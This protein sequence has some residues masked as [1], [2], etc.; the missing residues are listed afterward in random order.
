MDLKRIP[1]ILRHKIIH[2]ELEP[3]LIINVSDLAENYGVSRTPIK[4]ALILLQGE[5]WVIRHGSRFMVTPLSIKRLTDNIEIRMLMEPQAYIWAMQRMTNAELNELMDIE[6]QM[7]ELSVDEP[8]RSFGE[9]DQKFHDTLLRASK[10]IELHNS[11]SRIIGQCLRYW[12][13]PIEADKEVYFNSALEMIEAIRDKDTKRLKTA[14]IDHIK[15][16][17]P[18]MTFSL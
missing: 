8:A 1:E 12:L 18:E 7:R 5:G 2:L 6:L 15:M 10:N 4:E 9:L 16:S 3:E 11:L 14:T 17:L 13:S